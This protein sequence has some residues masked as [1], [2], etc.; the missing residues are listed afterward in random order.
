MLVGSVVKD[1]RNQHTG[2]VEEIL[3]NGNVRI[4]DEERKKTRE[5]A[6]TDIVEMRPP[7]AVS[8]QTSAYPPHTGG[9]ISS[10]LTEI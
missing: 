8:L 1:L 4:F 10:N 2:T 9:N 3:D 7:S 6:M 5:V